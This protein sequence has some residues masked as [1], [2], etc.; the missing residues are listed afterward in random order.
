MKFHEMSNSESVPEP[1]ENID[2]FATS[3]EGGANLVFTTKFHKFS[4]IFNKFSQIFTDLHK[5]SQVHKLSSV[6]TPAWSAERL[7]GWLLFYYH[8]ITLLLPAAR[9]PRRGRRRG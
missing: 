2:V 6:W 7:I 5:S 4:Q 9:G 1:H 3:G 8:S